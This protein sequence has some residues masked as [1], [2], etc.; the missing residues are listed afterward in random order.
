M[1]KWIEMKRVLPKVMKLKKGD[2]LIEVANEHGKQSEVR[3][4]WN[5]ISFQAEILNWI[6]PA[7]HVKRIALPE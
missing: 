5:G 7:G 2:Y 6:I 3:A 1:P 4:Y